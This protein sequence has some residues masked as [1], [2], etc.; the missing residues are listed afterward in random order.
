MAKKIKITALLLLSIITVACHAQTDIDTNVL[1]SKINMLRTEGCKCGDNTMHPTTPLVWNTTL[2]EAALDHS[3]YMDKVQRLEHQDADGNRAGKR[4]ARRGYI[5]RTYG[6][7]IAMGP[8]TVE[9]VLEIW[10]NSPSHCKNIMNPD[11]KE[12]G[13]AKSGKYWTQ[14]FAAPK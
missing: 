13:L 4:I 6:E 9:A 2:A 12:V 5:W 14:V 3:I 11:F 10:K 8:E 1:L 7:N